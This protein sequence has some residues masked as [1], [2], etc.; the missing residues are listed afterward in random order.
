MLGLKTFFSIYVIHFVSLAY[1]LEKLLNSLTKF[2]P[3]SDPLNPTPLTH[4]KDVFLHAK[5][6]LQT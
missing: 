5:L 2:R 3:F 1:H 6:V 4:Q